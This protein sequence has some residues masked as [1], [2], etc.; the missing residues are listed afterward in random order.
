MSWPDDY[1]HP[2]I[3]SIANPLIESADYILEVRVEKVEVDWPKQNRR[4]S[5][6]PVKALKGTSPHDRFFNSPITVCDHVYEFFREGEIEIVFLS[7]GKKNIYPR[8]GYKLS[9]K[10]QV[11]EYARKK[12]SKK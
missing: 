4:I 8:D 10:P 9:Y 11:D 1:K 12:L 7:S 3:E 2:S 5:F 6:V